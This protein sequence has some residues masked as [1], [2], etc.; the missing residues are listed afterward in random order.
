MGGQRAVARMKVMRQCTV[1]DV[2][3]GS[4][5]TDGG[6][7]R[8]DGGIDSPGPAAESLDCRAPLS[9]PLVHG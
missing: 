5:H 9:D 8:T 2:R 7:L 3:R 1:R 6:S 4:F